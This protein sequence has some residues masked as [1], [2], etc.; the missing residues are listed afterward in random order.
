MPADKMKKGT[1]FW[2]V[3]A[4]ILKSNKAPTIQPIKVSGKSVMSSRFW[5]FNSLREASDAPTPVKIKPAVLVTL[6]VTGG[7]PS[8]SRAGYETSDAR[9]PTVLTMPAATPIRINVRLNWI[10]DMNKA[11]F[12]ITN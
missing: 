8:A 6:A 4:G 11:L 2:N 10:N 7:S 5:C 12:S 1:I 9:P 3:S